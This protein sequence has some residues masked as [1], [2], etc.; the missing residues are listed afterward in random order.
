M[1]LSN[2]VLIRANANCKSRI[3][4][5]REPCH[6]EEQ[7]TTTTKRRQKKLR[8]SGERVES[9]Y[10]VPLRWLKQVIALF[11][12]PPAWVLTRAFFSSFSNATLHHSFWVSEEFWFFSVV[13]I[14][15]LITFFGL[16]KTMLMYVFGHEL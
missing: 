11:L 14:L 8:V 15:W 3:G 10:V 2:R 16:P 7:V 9:Y 5:R 13:A 1:V 12:V 4:D 6:S